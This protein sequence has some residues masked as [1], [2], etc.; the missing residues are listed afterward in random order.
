MKKLLIFLVV[1]A[2]I[3][4][5]GKFGLEKYYESKLDEAI[6]YAGAFASIDY[7]NVK[8]GTDG[9]ISIN[10]LSIRPR[11][12]DTY[13]RL[14]KIT[15]FSSDILLPINLTSFIKRNEFPDELGLRV[16]NLD[17]EP[18]V[19]EADIANNQQ[20]RRL[21]TTLI[22]D[23]IGI[24]RLNANIEMSLQMNPDNAV[25]DFSSTDQIAMMNSKVTFDS[26]ML[27][28]ARQSSSS[29]P[30]DEVRLNY[31]LNEQVASKVINSCANQLAI[32]TDDFLNTVVANPGFLRSTGLNFGVEANQ[33]LAEV[34]Q[35]GKWLSIR[36]KPNSSLNNLNSLSFYQPKDIIRLLG[37]KVSLDSEEIELDFADL[38]TENLN[39]NPV[40]EDASNTEVS[41]IANLEDKALE[42]LAVL[43]AVDESELTA[44]QLRIKRKL[45]D[46]A[47]AQAANQYSFKPT[48]INSL[49]R[50]I[51]YA[52]IVKRVGNKKQ[53]SG[54]L[55][56]TEDNAFI[57]ETGEYGGKANFTIAN[58]DAVEVLVYR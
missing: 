7:N 14:D 49:G 16:E 50:Y 22:S 44:E 35:G 9:S 13:V 17:Y 43:E 6:A 52:V 29:Q 33:A 34:M 12:I 1:V 31:K 24:N 23:V 48:S 56:A 11:S 57:I 10:N 45:E 19:F 41:S 51:N 36:S 26:S 58:Q 8:I 5:G 25:L 27:N 42:S 30:L 55:I 15:L 28:Q 47:A 38:A 18:S 4:F 21:E 37:L 39:V 3:V 40:S 46:D 54:E 2:A 53:M 20:C 32:S